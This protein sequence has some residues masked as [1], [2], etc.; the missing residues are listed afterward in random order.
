MAK[1]LFRTD[2]KDARK[3]ARKVKEYGEKRP[4]VRYAAA[5]DQLDDDQIHTCEYDRGNCTDG[6]VGC[7]V[8]QAWQEL[9]F[10]TIP[11][12]GQIASGQFGTFGVDG[13][14]ASKILRFLDVVQ[15]QQDQDE[16]WGTA[17]ERALTSSK[18]EDE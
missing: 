14:E 10:G 2:I 9:G 4:D 16:Q 18:W 7:I 8:G 3:L 6:T 13:Y 1:S 15:E 12:K 17:I 11:A 5:T